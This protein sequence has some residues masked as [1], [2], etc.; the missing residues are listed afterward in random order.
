MSTKSLI[1]ISMMLMA[2]SA[3][4]YHDTKPAT[5]SHESQQLTI[6]VE[7]ALV[8]ARLEIEYSDGS[9]L[10]KQP[11]R[12]RRVVIDFASASIGTYTIRIKKGDASQTHYYCKI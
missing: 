1:A 8:G 4:A 2:W 10:I 12:K 7:R 6:K 9:C 5:S 11:V 3:E